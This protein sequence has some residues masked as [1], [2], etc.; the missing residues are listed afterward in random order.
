M[1]SQRST[2][3]QHQWQ[4]RPWGPKLYVGSVDCHSPIL[5]GVDRFAALYTHSS[6]ATNSS[7]IIICTRLS[8]VAHQGV[9]DRRKVGFQYPGPAIQQLHDISL[10]LSLSSREQL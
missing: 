5:K 7:D 9:L 1:A 2:Q 4:F 3:Q 8:E 6:I 10:Q